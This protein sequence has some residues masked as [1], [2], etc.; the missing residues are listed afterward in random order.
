MLREK[1]VINLMEVRSESAPRKWNQGRD[2]GGRQRIVTRETVRPNHT[3]SQM[4]GMVTMRQVTVV[5]SE[6]QLIHT[7]LVDPVYVRSRSLL[8]Q[9]INSDI[10][11]V[12]CGPTSWTNASSDPN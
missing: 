3:D 7:P 12:V 6:R 9:F 2:V 8:A 1:G 4:R 11:L 10:V 5:F